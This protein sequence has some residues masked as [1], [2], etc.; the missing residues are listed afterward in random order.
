M[1]KVTLLSIYC[2]FAAYHSCLGTSILPQPPENNQSSI[3]VNEKERK[4]KE[5]L[6]ET[7][8]EIKIRKKIERELNDK[9]LEQAKQ[10]QRKKQNENN[11]PEESKKSLLHITL[12]YLPNRLID[13]TDI[14]TLEVGFG[15]EAS[16]ELTFTK[17]CQIGTD[18]GDKYFLKKGY[19]RQYGGGYHSGYN[20]SFICWNDEVAFTDY[21]FG[22]VKPYIVMDNE[23]GIPRPYKK[24]YSD[25]TRDFWDIALHI[26]WIIDL[27]IGLHPVAVANF[28]SGFFFVR[29]TDTKD[30]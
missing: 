12:M 27:S 30:L 7:R 2:L 26:G 3:T 6:N 20:V 9:K 17:Y 19:N 15:P 18:Y 1:R 21:T 16:C 22:T 28:F 23:L 29:L 8:M 11:K 5:S 13:L 24:P 10:E 14:V 4:L 25:G